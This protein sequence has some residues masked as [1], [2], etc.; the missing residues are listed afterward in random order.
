[1]AEYE[2]IGEVSALFLIF[3]KCRFW[4]LTLPKY[5]SLF[6]VTKSIL[7]SLQ[8]DISQSYNEFIER[9][10]WETENA[11]SFQN[12]CCLHKGGNDER[13]SSVIWT[14]PQRH[15]H[16]EHRRVYRLGSYHGTFH[17]DRLGSE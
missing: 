7:Y 14:V 5:L 3:P 16:A 15:G 11:C 13:K 17:R 12:N 4:C 10:E 9:N 2:K 1:M 8:Y 6:K